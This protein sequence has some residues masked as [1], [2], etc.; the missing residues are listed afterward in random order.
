[1]VEFLQDGIEREMYLIRANANEIDRIVDM[2]RKAFGTDVSVGGAEGNC[3]PDFDS[4]E[5]HNQM[6][7]EGHLYQAMIGEKIVGAA[8]LFPD[9]AGNSIYI[10]RIFIDSDY[11]RKGCGIRLME[12]IEKH[13]SFAA[14]FCLDTPSWNKRTRAFYQKAGYRVIKEENGFLFYQKK[15]T[16]AVQ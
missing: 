4:V 9:E 5:W 3:P 15:R 6:A 14:E 7:Q 16:Q 8:I 1:M 12:S 13:Y 2:S 10:G 11:H